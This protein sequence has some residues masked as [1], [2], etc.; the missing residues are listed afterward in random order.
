MRVRSVKIAEYRGLRDLQLHLPSP[1]HARFKNLAV[2][3]IVG[4][5]GTGKTTLFRAMAHA[6]TGRASANDDIT[7]VFDEEATGYKRPPTRVII[8]SYAASDGYKGLRR[9]TR[10]PATLH[11][12]GAGRWSSGFNVESI[13]EGRLGLIIA[14]ALLGDDL[15]KQEAAALFVEFLEYAPSPYLFIDIDLL[16]ARTR[17]P[18]QQRLDLEENDRHSDIRQAID[19]L[20]SLT[21]L[22]STRRLAQPDGWIS[23]HDWQAEHPDLIPALLE[24]LQVLVITAPRVGIRI[25]FQIGFR[26]TQAV[27]PTE[28]FSSGERAMLYRFFGLLDLMQ[29]HALVLIDEPEVH[30]HPAW[31]QRFIPILIN[32]FREYHAHLILASHSPLIA[33][34]LPADCVLILQRRGDQIR[35]QYLDEPSLGSDPKRVLYQIFELDDY[36]GGFAQDV[37]QD[38]E[39]SLRQGDLGSAE[40]SYRLLADSHEKYRL[41]LELEKRRSGN[42]RG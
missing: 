28:S 3:L 38:V 29:D 35:G 19:H 12:A 26:R 40:R 20:V 23:L 36:I 30:L 16:L 5:N 21:D 13:S 11:Y 8:S 17:T 39:N 15:K 34:D 1:A 4:K 22:E 14:N 37:I 33:T 18:Y 10:A 6:L 41:F 25:P 24:A 27:V 9:S 2:T 42:R 31:I 32:V 7:M